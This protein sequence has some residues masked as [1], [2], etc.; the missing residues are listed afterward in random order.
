MGK[1]RKRFNEKARAGTIAKQLSL[2]AARNKHLFQSE[3]ESKEVTSPE[4]HNTEL[5]QTEKNSN[6]EVLKPLTEEEKNER[7]RR[8]ETL[9]YKENEKE[10]KLSR[11]KKK[12]LDKYIEHQLK[13]EE[14]KVLLQKLSQTKIDSD[15]LVPSKLL[16]KGKQT[17]KEEMIEALE[18]ERQNRGDERTK[19]ILYEERD[20]KDWDDQKKEESESEMSDKEEPQASKEAI[21][22]ERQ[23]SNVGSSSFIDHRPAKF[24]GSGFGFGFGNLPT[25]KSSTKKKKPYTWK[26]R[27]E[28]VQ[29]KKLNEEEEMD[30]VN[31][32]EEGT[33]EDENQKMEKG[34]VDDEDES[35]EEESG[36]E[37]SNPD[38]E[39]EKEDDNED[40]DDESSSEEETEDEEDMHDS[41]EDVDA[42]KPQGKLKLSHS[43]AAEDFKKWA[44]E[45]VRKIEG[46][47]E[48]AQ[49]PVVPQEVLEKYSKPTV[50]EEDLEN[51]SDEE[52]YVPI[53]PDLQRKSLYVDVERDSAIQEQRL[54]LPVFSEEFKIMEAVHH[55]DCV[56]ICGETG[57]GKTTQVPQF[58]YEAGFGSTE[59]DLYPGMIGITQPRRVAAIAMSER[60]GKELGS[61]GDRVSYQVRFDS[62]M[63]RKKEGKPDTSMKFMTDGIL[64]REMMSDLLLT[65]YSALIIDEAHERNINT[66]ILI[67]MLSRVLKL[68]RRKHEESPEKFMPLKLIIMS[69]TLRVS[70]FAENKALFPNT[71]T[72]LQIGSRQFPVSVHFNRRTHYDYLE[73]AFRKTSKIHRRLPPGGILVFLTGQDEIKTLVSRLRKELPSPKNSKK[74]KYEADHVVPDVKASVHTVPEVEE[75]EFSVGD[76]KDK[77]SENS[78]VEDYN[79]EEDDEEGFEESL[80]SHQTSN[81]PLY[82]L[83]LYSLLPTSEQ[84]K[85]FEDPPEGS[86]ICIVA[87]NIAETSLTIPGIRY[88]VD[89]GRSKERKYNE[90]NGVQSYEIDWVS[91]ASANQRSGRAGRTGPG[92]CYRLYS[93]AVYE[94]YFDQFSKPEILRMP[95]ESVVLTMKSMGIDQIVNFP[96]PTPPDLSALKK[97]EN[98][99][100]I[101][102][103]LDKETKTISELGKKMSLFPLSPRF[104]KILI[105]GNQFGCLPYIIAIVCVLSVGSPLLN[106]NDIGIFDADDSAESESDEHQKMSEARKALRTKFFKSRNMFSRL[107]KN[108]DALMLL[109]VVCAFD[110]VPPANRVDF[111]KHNFLRLKTMEEIVKLRKQVMHL[112]HKYTSVDSIASSIN[113]SDELKLGMP[114][115]KQV[116]AIKQMIASGFLDQVAARA[117]AISSDVKLSNK[118]FSVRV[119]YTTVFPHANYSD[120]VDPYVYIHP[121]S[122]L[123]S[124]SDTPPTYLVYHSLTLQKRQK[125]NKRKVR[126]LPLVDIKGRE[127]T[128][129]AK[130]SSLLS[131]S[132][133]LG[134]PYAPK[135]IGNNKRECYVVPRFGAIN[136]GQTGWDL[137]V[138]KVLQVKKNGH[139]VIE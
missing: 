84:M 117:D 72:I 71:P 136:I 53:N 106:E 90:E 43:K 69:A 1:Y 110:H 28:A 85:V 15:L 78:L 64:L 41:E 99:L 115:K 81:D 67:G 92:H 132:K 16:G 34:T 55:H 51:S 108:C 122:I 30:F 116:A 3:D 73:E 29:S 17:K 98:A 37:I 32:E 12:R 137:P 27:L 111:V 103:A 6:S 9:L 139:W 127:L 40:E 36:S 61:H 66:D 25:I 101:L 35:S 96:F 113:D 95:V 126:I 118:T 87:T 83:P 60:V 56:I 89:C 93:S 112:V 11:T 120:D 128:N 52:N 14:K 8:L 91:K 97:A 13:R 130:N 38:I 102:G 79:S 135:D 21:S 20:V 74:G 70:D 2:K 62:S 109:S 48:S 138:T 19:E 54:K 26:N 33:S 134:H 129:I 49:L 24:G 10:S 100:E 131:Y 59:S 58:L 65:N 86:R 133:P 124:S 125:E 57:S 77:G 68:R 80:E 104:A 39:D 5:F 94:N 50:R 63:K 121:A 18:L 75:L 23:V 76:S 82:V 105:I 88:V 46:R 22:D 45:E 42:E 7:K 123:A 4:R 47:D 114:D 44:E 31:S 107:D 119:P